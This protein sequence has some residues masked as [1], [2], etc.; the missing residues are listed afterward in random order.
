MTILKPEI[1]RLSYFC[2]YIKADTYGENTY[3]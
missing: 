1:L 3:Y 2:P